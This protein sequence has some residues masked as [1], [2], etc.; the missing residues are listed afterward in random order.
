MSIHNPAKPGGDCLAIR[1][2][3]LALLVAVTSLVACGGAK[4]SAGQPA[5]KVGKAE[6]TVQQVNFMLQQQRGLKPEQADQAS[7][8]ILERLIDQEIAVQKANDLK[9]DRDPRVLL[10]IDVARREILARAYAEKVAEAASKPG[11]ED[12]QKYYDENPAL[13]SQRRIYNLQEIA[14]EAG[15][16]QLP[17]LREKLAAAKNVPE[18]LEYLKSNNIRFAGNQAV[19]SAEQLPLAMIKT[20]AAMKDGQAFIASNPNGI[21]VVVLAGSR[22]Q[23]VSA[24][25]AQPAIEQFLLNERKR[26]LLEEHRKSLREAAKIQYFG[27]FAEAAAS[28]ATAGDVSGAD[29]SAGG[30]STQ[31]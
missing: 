4:D 19:R 31:K 26:K 12:V 2:A 20:F 15:A 24:D 23:P 10:L 28:A 5:A 30:A 18:F 7:R 14:V 13:F 11:A 27:Q 9:L 6:I 16:D 29:A 1:F 8:Q 25:Q 22:E 3:R 21:Q 17:A